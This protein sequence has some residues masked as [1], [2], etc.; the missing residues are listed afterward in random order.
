MAST[1]P[2]AAPCFVGKKNV[3]YFFDAIEQ[4]SDNVNNYS[5]DFFGSRVRGRFRAA[6]AISN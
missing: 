4:D 3:S 5:P 2:R 6:S 1:K